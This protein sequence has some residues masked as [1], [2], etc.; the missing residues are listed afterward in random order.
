MAEQHTEGAVPVSTE[1]ES[2]NS[3]AGPLKEVV[4]VSSTVESEAKGKGLA[5]PNISK[6]K[7]QPSS[8][9]AVAGQADS[10]SSHGVQVAEVQ[11][12][13]GNV[14]PSRSPNPPAASHEGEAG[15][16]AIHVSH[17]GPAPTQAQAEAEVAQGCNSD[18]PLNSLQPS[19]ST[20]AST[21]SSAVDT[22]TASQN[23][24]VLPSTQTSLDA[25]SDISSKPEVSL[26]AEHPSAPV[27]VAQT[28]QT[29]Q[30]GAQAST[31]PPAEIEPVSTE[32]AKPDRPDEPQSSAPV[33]QPTVQ[34]SSGSG[35]ERVPQNDQASTST[36]QQS[37]TVD[38][39]PQS[40]AQPTPQ[41][42]SQNTDKESA[43]QAVAPSSS[44]PDN[45]QG[46]GQSD[47]DANSQGRD[48]RHRS[49][50]RTRYDVEGMPPGSRIFIGNLATERLTKADLIKTFSRY[51]KVVE[52]SL[53]KSFGFLQ[54]DNPESAQA[55]IDGESGKVFSG[56]T[57]GKRA[58]LL[59]I[60]YAQA[61]S[62]CRY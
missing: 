45:E 59:H 22:G 60:Y 44:V 24:T 50:S 12:A 23:V 62:W 2:V 57:L 26:A 39:A 37:A 55:S 3:A 41:A 5:L 28:E 18:V 52:V 56:L 40:T 7:E 4:D 16:E 53:H 47:T 25:L 54:F 34:T 8:E 61:E 10:E 43:Q 46:Q 20:D 35:E 36:P 58:Y 13:E 49:P 31:Q 1:N 6:N 14:E 30:E 32:S 48:S 29:S 42:P 11:V 19:G 27:D 33:V 51:G 21:L 9:L 15:G 17:I 38:E